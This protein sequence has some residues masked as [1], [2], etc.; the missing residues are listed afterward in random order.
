MSTVPYVIEK[1]GKDERVYD[2][3]SRLLKDRVIFIGTGI[4]EHVANSVVA[5]L[6]FLEANDNESD[7]YMYISSPGGHVTAGLAIYDTMQYVKPDVCTICYGMAASMASIL[8]AAGTTGKRFILPSAEVM[9][10]QPLGGFEGQVSDMKIRYDH[11][12]NLQK[13]LY[14]IYCDITGKS[15]DEIKEACDRDNYMSAEEAIAFGLVDDIQTK[16]E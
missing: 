4:D 16:R 7:I 15:F 13:R 1:D 11:I 14:N 5:Q 3:Y 10:H 9:I 12:E 2:L 6:L 8:L